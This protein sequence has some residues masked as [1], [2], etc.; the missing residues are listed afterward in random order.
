MCL[1]LRF[2]LIPSISGHWFFQIRP[3]VSILK[4]ISIFLLAV[5]PLVSCNAQV[6]EGFNYQTVVRDVSGGLIVNSEVCLKLGLIQNSQIEYEEVHNVTTN[7]LG[8]IN[9]ILGYGQ[10]SIGTFESIEWNGSAVYVQIS[11]SLN[12][13]GNYSPVGSS[14]LMSVPYSL[15]AHSSGNHVDVGEATGDIKFWN[16]ASWQ[17]LPIGQEGQVLTVCGG[18]P[19]WTFDGICPIDLPQVATGS[20][21]V[22]ANS[23]VA[24][25]SIVSDGGAAINNVGFLWGTNNP[26]TY[27]DNVIN[28]G[29]SQSGFQSIV[30]GLNYSTTY[31]I[32]AFA[33]NSQGVG[34]GDVVAVE[35]SMD[36]LMSL[37]IGDSYGGGIVAYIL[38]PG[39]IGY[40]SNHIQGIIAAPEDQSSS[41]TWGCYGQF[42][43]STSTSI[44]T[45]GMNTTNIVNGCLEQGIAARLCSDLILNGYDDWYLPSRAELLL[46]YESRDLIG[47]FSAGGYWSSSQDKNTTAWNVV[48]SGGVFYDRPK[49]QTYRVRAIR[50]F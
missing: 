41:A 35:T 27:S 46:L 26:P 36:P 4:L 24:N 18:I 31:Y 30:N 12:C 49:Y 19:K 45:G 48:F 1:L 37:Q 20:V 3:S 16:G 14:Q 42:V 15:Y 50:R 47:G 29:S 33:S 9:L 13:D 25:G 17:I 10:P 5:Y 2:G 44:S 6:P 11:V 40:T 38:Q 21:Q 39:D 34:Y 23:V 32:R 7:S 22:T 43:S 8:L 28:L